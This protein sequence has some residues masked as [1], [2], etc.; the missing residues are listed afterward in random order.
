MTDDF[1]IKVGG[2]KLEAAE[3]QY[4]N[5]V[6]RHLEDRRQQTA[7]ND[8]TWNYIDAAIDAVSEL[9]NFLLP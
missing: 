9:R 8:P 5:D 3:C 1:E 7:T 2:E 6:L 4:L